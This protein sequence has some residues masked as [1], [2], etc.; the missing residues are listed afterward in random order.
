MQTEHQAEYERLHEAGEEHE[1]TEDSCTALH[2]T[3]VCTQSS[4]SFV[5]VSADSNN[6]L[7]AVQKKQD[8]AHCYDMPCFKL[9]TGR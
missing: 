4:A 3:E 8:S 9:Y 2:I 7:A 5:A 6:V 1:A